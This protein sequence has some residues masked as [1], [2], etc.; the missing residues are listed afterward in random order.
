VLWLKIGHVRPKCQAGHATLP[1]GQ[2]S[3]LHH[4]WSLETLSTASAG[5]VDKTVFGNAPTHGRPAQV[6]WP[7]GHTLAWLSP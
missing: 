2:V 7:A 3:S 6:M 5:H 1:G 4:L